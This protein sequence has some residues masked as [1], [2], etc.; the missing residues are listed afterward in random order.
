MGSRFSVGLITGLLVLAACADD[1]FEYDVAT[2]GLSDAYLT[3]KSQ[4]LYEDEAF[5]SYNLVL[6]DEALEFL[7]EDPTAEIYV[8]GGLEYQ[9]K[10][11][12]AGIR[13]K[14]SVG[15]WHKGVQRCVGT[16]F[17]SPMPTGP[18]TCQKLS[19]KVSFNEYDP[20]GRFFGLKKVLFHAMNQDP[21]LMR[22]RLA[23]SIFREMGVAAPRSSHAKVSI[24]GEFNGVYAFVEYIDGRFTRSRFEDG[25][26]NLYKEIWP[27][28]SDL[29]A[30]TTEDALLAA[31]RTNEDE[32]PTFAAFMG[33]SQ[34]L[35]AAQ[36]QDAQLAAA[37]RWLDIDYMLRYVAADRATLHDDGI[38]H[39]YESLA[40][41]NQVGSGWYNHNFYWYESTNHARLW[42]IPWDM[43]NTWN[44]DSPVTHVK[45]EWNDVEA[46]CDAVTVQGFGLRQI[47][48]ACDPLIRAL[49]HPE[50]AAK[51]EAYVAEVLDGPL[52]EAAVEKK[53]SRWSAQIEDAVAEASQFDGELSMEAW[54]KA[55]TGL[56][57]AVAATRSKLARSIGRSSGS[58]N[59]IAATGYVTAGQMGPVLSGVQVCAY[60][61]SEVDCATTDEEGAFTL[62]GLAA[63]TEATLTFDKAGFVPVARNFNFGDSDYAGSLDTSTALWATGTYIPA[64]AQG[65]GT[66]TLF[67]YG[68]SAGKVA[69]VTPDPG[70]DVLYAGE[71]VDG[72]AMF[73]PDL[74]KTSASGVAIY[75]DVEPGE[76]HVNFEGCSGLSSTEWGLPPEDG[77]TGTRIRVIPDYVMAPGVLLCIL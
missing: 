35:T 67:P 65:T 4:A 27:S 32:M 24:N 8:K 60:E 38:M 18:K 49:A 76:Y 17:F 40:Q 63:S 53:I 55:K 28:G 2:E 41:G 51:Y 30:E 56:L 16:G 21:S 19:L 64:P 36:D 57:S 52:S 3:S 77:E 12:E 26:G 5:E 70:V 13:Y 61:Q 59:T 46:G 72:V 31:L 74:T 15:A 58:A 20:D 10:S 47:P 29:F 25:E 14:G 39:F 71:A 73:D 6:T 69:A 23:Y 75:A 34:D 66:L 11:Y 54:A 44:I 7:D 22:E 50:L 1:D 33:L 43:D 37:R 48:P 9:G 45:T 62:A 68:M 42:L